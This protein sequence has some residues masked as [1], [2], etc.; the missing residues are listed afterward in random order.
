[1]IILARLFSGLLTL[2]STGGS[3]L[4][5][6]RSLRKSELTRVDLPRPL[7]PTTIRVNSKPRFTDLRWTCGGEDGLVPTFYRF[8]LANKNGR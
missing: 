4:F 1:M 2:S 6:Y 8:A 3:F 5:E 7:S